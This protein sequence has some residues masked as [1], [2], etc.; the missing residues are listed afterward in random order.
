MIPLESSDAEPYN[1][2]YVAT[3]EK[4]KAKMEA[5]GS[6]CDLHLYEGQPHGFFNFGRAGG[7]FYKKTVFEM[8]KFL[9]SLG[10]LDGEP[11]IAAE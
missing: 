2:L 8:D 6:R 5:A 3:A 1:G 10:Y 4:Y 7:E 11:T 9:A